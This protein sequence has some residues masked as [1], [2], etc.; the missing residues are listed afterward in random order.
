MTKSTH[1]GP[2]PIPTTDA[3]E[4]LKADHHLVKGLFAEFEKVGEEAQGTLADKICNAL[5][6]HTQIEEEI[7]YPAARNA[8]GPQGAKL[9]DEAV[10]EHAAAKDLIAK[11][12][13]IG[14]GKKFF[15]AEVQV[16]GEQIQH[17]VKEEEGELFPK[18]KNSDMDRHA[19][20]ERML[21]RKQVLSAEVALNSRKANEPAA[22]PAPPDSRQRDGASHGGAGNRARP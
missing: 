12:E 3:I 5:K 2:D 19:V 18:V 14:P 7:F 4:L 8:L 20:G 15:A 6:V 11:I 21:K 13:K 1:S 22:A 10:V 16:L 17:H 9:L